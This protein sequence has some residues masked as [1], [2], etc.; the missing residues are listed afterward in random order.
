MTKVTLD[1]GTFKALA[2]DTRL[3]ILKTLDGKKMSLKDICAVTKLNKATLHEHLAKLNEVGLVKRNER[4]GHKWV[5]YKLTWKGE[6]LLHPENTRIVVM[7]ATTFIALAVGVVQMIWYV[8]GTVMNFGNRA[9]LAGNDMLMDGGASEGLLDE[10]MKSP[11]SEMNTLPDLFSGVPEFLRNFFIDRGYHSSES[12]YI[13]YDADYLGMG[14]VEDGAHLFVDESQ[15]V[16]H[17]L[18]QNPMFLYIAITCF[19]VF[20]IVL[21]FSLWRLRENKTPQL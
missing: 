7:F 6:S 11:S 10:A 1:M 5:T 16:M 8:K 3:D 2:S 13:P 21:C 19:A 20:T 9:F 17:T 18:Y 14:N 15:G 12:S 4:E